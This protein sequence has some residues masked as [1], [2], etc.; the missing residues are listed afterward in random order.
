MSGAWKKSAAAIVRVPRRAER[1]WKQASSAVRATG[2]SAAGIGVGDRP[3]DRPAVADRRV[4]DVAHGL[5]EQRPPAR[6]DA[7]ALERRLPRQRADAQRAVRAAQVRE[8]GDDAVEVD[9]RRR[10]REAEVQERDERL[11]ARERL[12]VLA[13]HRERGGDRVR[14]DVV[15]RGRLHVRRRRSHAAP[16]SPRRHP[17]AD[18]EHGARREPAPPGRV[19]GGRGVAPEDENASRR[20]SSASS[21]RSAAARG[22]AGRS[23]LPRDREHAGAAPARDADLGREG[24]PAEAAGA[25]RLRVDP[26]PALVLVDVDEPQHPGVRDAVGLD[27]QPARATSRPRPRPRRARPRRRC[28]ARSRSRS[29]A[30]LPQRP[31]QLLG[32]ERRVDV[33]PAERVGD[34]RWRA[35]AARRSRRPRP[36][37][38]RRAGSAARATPPPRGA[39]AGSRPRSAARSRAATRCAAGRSRRGR[40]PRSGTARCPG[41]CRRRPGRGR[42]AG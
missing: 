4:G 39:A 14:R 42:A 32:R 17:G 38:S 2:S 5:G 31:P 10:A 8:L 9:E 15:E 11:A 33:A 41:R 3:A 25:A 27:P 24:H 40:P 37:P 23:G 20:E 12:R 29:P 7:R 16:A 6:D 35:R 30:R 36:R 22:V 13:Q 26:G 34:A 1:T 21:A 28:A 19:V 18:R